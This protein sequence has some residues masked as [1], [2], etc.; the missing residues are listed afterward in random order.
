MLM[1]L[2]HRPD[3]TVDDN[4]RWLE[5]FG[6]NDPVVKPNQ[7]N[8]HVLKVKPE[9]IAK[10]GVYDIYYDWKKRRYYEMID[11]QDGCI[12]QFAD[13][14][15]FNNERPNERLINQIKVTPEEAFNYGP[16]SEDDD[17]MPF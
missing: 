3:P 4:G 13:C 11:S 6:N 17:D 8:I 7:T 5:G 16:E 14:T 1:L 15:K 10:W 12:L 9:G 2:V